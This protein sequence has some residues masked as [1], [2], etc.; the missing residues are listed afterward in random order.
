MINWSAFTLF[1]YIL[2]RMSGFVLFSPLYGR[3]SVPG[4]VKAGFI[5]ML[6]VA[7]YGACS[8]TVVPPTNLLEFLLHLLLELSMGFV[9]AMIMRFFFTIADLA[10][11]PI[12]TQMGMSMGRTYDPGSQ[13]SMTNTASIMSMM[14]ML[15]FFAANGHIT[16]LRIMLTSGELVPFGQVALN[17]NIPSWMLQLFAECA[18]LAVKLCLPVLAAELMGQVGMGVLMKVIPQI[19]V[20]AIN[21]EFKVL[22]GL[23]MLLMLMAPISSFMLEVEGDM[24]DRLQ[25]ILQFFNG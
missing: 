5:L 20:F 25:D 7:V 11:E 2:M 14:M 22:V 19:N 23:A 13:A 24:L 18:L 10:G 8:Q 16:M 12:D 6:A 9:L 4:I 3:S 17:E 1:L 21:I 15:L